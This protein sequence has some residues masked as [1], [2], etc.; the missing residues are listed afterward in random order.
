LVIVMLPD[1]QPVSTIFLSP[2]GSCFTLF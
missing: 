2:L 1:V